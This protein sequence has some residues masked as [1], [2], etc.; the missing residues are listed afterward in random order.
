MD[1]LVKLFD[2]ALTLLVTFPVTMYHLAFRPSLV[3]GPSMCPGGACLVLGIAA[4]YSGVRLG[5]RVAPTSEREAPMRPLD[6]SSL[7]RIVVI[8]IVGL[9]IQYG[10]FGL[11]FQ[12]PSAEPI[13]TIRLLAFPMALVPTF[14]APLLV[15]L[16]GAALYARTLRRD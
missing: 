2:S 4:Y 12:L 16:H 13:H 10:A 1:D 8:A 11:L 15:L 3:F 6:K 5:E 14:V 9:A 7:T